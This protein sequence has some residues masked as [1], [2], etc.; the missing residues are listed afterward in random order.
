[1]DSSDGKGKANFGTRRLEPKRFWT[2]T[3]A[4]TPHSPLTD[5]LAFNQR[6][7][8]HVTCRSFC[9]LEAVIPTRSG[10]RLAAGA[11]RERERTS[12]LL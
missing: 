1:M 4:G 6:F 7:R 2:P 8:S 5:R 9:I 10:R 11:G 12:S 3:G